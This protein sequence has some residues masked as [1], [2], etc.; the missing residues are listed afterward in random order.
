ME[1]VHTVRSIATVSFRMKFRPG[2]ISTSPTSSST[3]SSRIQRSQQTGLGAIV[4]E[5][6]SGLT[7]TGATVL[8]N[9]E[10]LPHSILY[11]RAQLNF[12]GGMGVIVLAVAI[13]PLLGIGGMQLYRAET[14]GPM[15]DEMLTPRIRDTARHLWFVYVGLAMACALSYWLAGMN[16]FD[17]VANSFSTLSLGGFSTHNDSIGFFHSP[18]IEVVGRVF[19]LLAGVNYALYFLA[20]RQVSLMVILRNAEFQL[21]AAVMALIIIVTC[22]YPR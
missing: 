20:W 6:T 12:L 11:Y 10:G 1:K 4:F 19:S 14:P 5:A 9:L 15:K 8:S 16:I 17:A 2:R 22:L 13:Q 18:D 21:Y 7:T 3:A